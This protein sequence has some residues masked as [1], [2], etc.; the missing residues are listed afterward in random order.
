MAGR[1]ECSDPRNERASERARRAL[2][3]Q[4]QVLLFVCL[5]GVGRS[6]DDW[7][8]PVGSGPGRLVE[9]Q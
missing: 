2:Q 9:E 6:T 8:D 4:A 3:A 5:F 7:T 1:A